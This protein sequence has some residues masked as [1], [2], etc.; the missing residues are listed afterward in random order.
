L[1]VENVN[2]SDI[3]GLLVRETLLD[4]KLRTSL[5]PTLSVRLAVL[6]PPCR[7]SVSSIIVH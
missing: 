3:L 5:S 6:P 2:E 7:W 4:G 1:D